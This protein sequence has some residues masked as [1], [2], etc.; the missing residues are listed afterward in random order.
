[1]GNS[2]KPPWEIPLE[3][4]SVFTQFTDIW[5]NDPLPLPG[6]SKMVAGCP[7][8]NMRLIPDTKEALKESSTCLFPCSNRFVDACYPSSSSVS[9]LA[10]RN[11]L[12]PSTLTIRSARPGEVSWYSLLENV[13]FVRRKK[14]RLHLSVKG[15]KE[16]ILVND[17]LRMCRKR[18]LC[19][20]E[21]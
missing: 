7:C 19:V 12:L 9:I 16:W 3:V 6:L 4:D 20:I 8:D 1:M 21:K 17:R 10:A 11:I 5:L 18:Q 13:Y 14:W 2:M 15:M